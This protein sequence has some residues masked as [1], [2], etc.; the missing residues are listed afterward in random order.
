VPGGSP[1]LANPL[2]CIP[3]IYSAVFLPRLSGTNFPVEIHSPQ[4]SGGILSFDG[5]AVLSVNSQGFF[6]LAKQ[7]HFETWDQELQKMP[8]RRGSRRT[9]QSNERGS[10]YLMRCE[11]KGLEQAREPAHRKFVAKLIGEF[12]QST[13]QP[14]CPPFI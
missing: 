13:R 9:D 3:P 12:R 1:N 11:A 6:I 2:Y 8:P 4:R 5:Y 14:F 10:K 7:D